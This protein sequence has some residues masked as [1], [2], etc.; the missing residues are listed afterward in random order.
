M[1]IFREEYMISNTWFK[2]PHRQIY[3]WKSPQDNEQKV[4]RNYIDFALIHRRF[5]S[6]IQTAKANPGMDIGSDRLSKTQAKK[7]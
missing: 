7:Q 3:I 2:L 6:S 4:V 1:N 5:K